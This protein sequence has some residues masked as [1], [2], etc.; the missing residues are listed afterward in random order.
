[1]KAEADW[2]DQA[3]VVDT[4]RNSVAAAA[5]A[6][7]E[8]ATRARTK[9]EVATTSLMEAVVERDNVKLAYQRVIENKGAAGVEQAL[10]QVLQPI[11]EPTSSD[12]S[13]GFRPGRN[14]HQALRRARQYV[15]SGKRW[16]VDIDLKQFFDRVNHDL[17]LSKL[18]TKIGDARVLT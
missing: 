7:A 2:E 1:M 18:A 15:A 13:Y 5:R 14:A 11:F 16:V 4:G 8:M 10:H 6:E 9:A 12:A 17:L 3:G